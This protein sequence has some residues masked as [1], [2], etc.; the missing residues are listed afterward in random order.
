LETV[1][2]PP[3]SDWKVANLRGTLDVYASGTRLHLLRGRVLRINAELMARM[4]CRLARLH[5]A[6]GAVA[7]YPENYYES[8]HN[9][10]QNRRAKQLEQLVGKEFSCASC[11]TRTLRSSADHSVI[12]RCCDEAKP[13]PRSYCAFAQRRSRRGI[14][15][16]EIGMLERSGTVRHPWETG[17][18]GTSTVRR[19]SNG[20][21]DRLSLWGAGIHR[22]ENSAAGLW[23]LALRP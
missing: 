18:Q 15:A 8:A 17:E 23:S 20:L 4:A 9:L 14:G 3:E 16:S 19:L 2:N 13:G 5:D 1:T 6:L 11:R 7:Q 12:N 10:M 21:L 22:A